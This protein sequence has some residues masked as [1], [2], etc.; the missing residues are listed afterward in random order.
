[1]KSASVKFITL[2]VVLVLALSGSAGAVIKKK[3]RF[4]LQHRSQIELRLG[5]FDGVNLDGDF[6]YDGV[7][8]RHTSDDLLVAV[9]FNHW[10]DETLAFNVSVRVLA[11][12]YYSGVSS[13]GTYEAGYAVVPIFV[14]FRHYLGRPGS[15]S[16]VRP[17]LTAAGGP[18][19]GS[20]S[21]S[22]VGYDVVDETRTVTAGG[23]H[24]GG[25]ID[26]LVSRHVM[27]GVN[28]GYNLISDFDEPIGGH[29]NY[30][31]AEFGV[32]FGFVF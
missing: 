8:S 30:S 14:G 23:A 29:V 15:W 5:L 10:A 28:G 1:M 12:D 18:V 11:S 26:F 17:Y 24:L 25:G 3:S 16:T 32:G 21:L 9:G 4:R 2:G 6:F 20:Q 7:V 31:G 19:I 13:A 22:L 27:F